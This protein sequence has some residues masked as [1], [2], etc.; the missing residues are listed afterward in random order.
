MPLVSGPRRANCISGDMRVGEMMDP[1]GVWTPIVSLPRLF[2]G[3]VGG[4]MDAYGPDLGRESLSGSPSSSMI[5]RRSLCPRL[6]VRAGE[7]GG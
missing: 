7:D 1:V 6:V 4:T 5:L 2:H 3:D